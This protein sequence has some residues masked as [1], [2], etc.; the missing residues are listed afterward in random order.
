MGYDQGVIDRRA[1]IAREQP[2]TEL[3]VAALNAEA[4]L[5]RAARGADRW[6]VMIL[7]IFL[8]SLGMCLANPV[9]GIVP[10]IASV[11]GVVVQ[12]RKAKRYLRG[13]LLCG[14]GASC[15][16]DVEDALLVGDGEKAMKLMLSPRV[17]QELRRQRLPAARATLL[18]R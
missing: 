9:I 11:A 16:L 13:A 5:K 17:S 10:V 8:L 14:N 3:S 1:P 15:T 2:A 7:W 18:D 4:A 12:Q 6:L